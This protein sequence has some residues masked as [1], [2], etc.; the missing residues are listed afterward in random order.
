MLW[1]ETL[2]QFGDSQKAGLHVFRQS[3]QLCFDRLI[4]NFNRPFCHSPSSIAFL[5]CPG[6][7]NNKM[8]QIG[9][10]YVMSNSLFSRI[11]VSGPMIAFAKLFLGGFL[12]RRFDPFLNGVTRV[13]M[14]Q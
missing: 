10:R 14:E 8:Q 4:E 12:A 5:L 9:P 11:V 6:K 13:V 3:K 1:P 2:Q 7:P